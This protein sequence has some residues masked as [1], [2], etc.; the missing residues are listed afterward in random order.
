MVAIEEGAAYFDGLTMRRAGADGM[1]SFVVIDRKDG[2][3]EE[4]A[5][6]FKR[7]RF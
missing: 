3:K 6:R 7:A 1:E 2:K 5:F 4:A